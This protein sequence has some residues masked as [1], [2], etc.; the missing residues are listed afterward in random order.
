MSVEVKLKQIRCDTNGYIEK[1]DDADPTKYQH[2]IEIKV[3]NMKQKLHVA[4]E[5]D[6]ST[7]NKQ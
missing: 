4:A 7:V 2:L 5:P 3:V 6:K 1:I